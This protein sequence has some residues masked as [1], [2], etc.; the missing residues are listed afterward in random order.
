MQLSQTSHFLKSTMKTHPPP[1]KNSAL[2]MRTRRRFDTCKKHTFRQIGVKKL[3]TDS[4]VNPNVF[5]SL[6]FHQDE[7]G[8]N[9]FTTDCEMHLLTLC[10]V[11]SK[12]A[13]K[14][15]TCSSSFSLPKTEL[16][17]LFNK[18]L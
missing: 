17:S 6:M 7:Y 9:I 14:S 11:H 1:Q 15:A 4:T 12:T 8:E 10:N 5:I 2:A 13:V 3:Q 16:T 18:P